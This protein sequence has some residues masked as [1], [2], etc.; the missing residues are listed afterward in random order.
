M[1]SEFAIQQDKAQWQMPKPHLIQCRKG[2]KFET[3]IGLLKLFSKQLSDDALEMEW[4]N[5]CVVV[6]IL[7]P[8]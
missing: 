8:P 2:K 5:R 1:Y 6:S 4:E 3:S 7:D